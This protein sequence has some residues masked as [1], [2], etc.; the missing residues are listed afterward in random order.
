MSCL[1]SQVQCGFAIKLFSLILNS[2]TRVRHELAPD[3]NKSGHFH[4]T[5]SR[6]Q[7]K[8]HLDRAMKLWSCLKSNDINSK[9][10]ISVQFA[11]MP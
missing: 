3:E 4:L 9:Y 1:N 6:Y 5:L 2:A 7:S 11:S 10:Y 8:L